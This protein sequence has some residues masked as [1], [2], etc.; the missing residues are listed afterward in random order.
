MPTAYGVAFEDSLGKMHRA[1]LNAGDNNEIIL[2][3]GALGS[4]QLL[5]LSGIGPKEQLD[6]LKINCVLEQPFVGKDVADNP[7]NAFFIPSPIAVERS[8]VQVVGI[9]PFGSYIEAVGGS[10]SILANVSAYQGF[11]PEVSTLFISNSN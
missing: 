5:V 3:A 2:S 1:F 8:I 7:Q 10:N 9:T 11:T 6:A 4:P